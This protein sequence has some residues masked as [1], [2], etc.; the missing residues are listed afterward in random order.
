M[1]AAFCK[2]DILRAQAEAPEYFDWAVE[3]LSWAASELHHLT[4]VLA[5]GGRETKKGA[6]KELEA[7]EAHLSALADAASG[8][9]QILGGDIYDRLSTTGRRALIDAV[10]DL[11]SKHTTWRPG[12]GRL[13]V[14]DPIGWSVSD[15]GVALQRILRWAEVAQPIVK[16]GAE[17][18]GTAGADAGREELTFARKA[19]TIWLTLDRSDTEPVRVPMRKHFAEWLEEAFAF[20]RHAP[21]N[22]STAAEAVDELSF[23][24]RTT[25]VPQPP[26]PFPVARQ[27]GPNQ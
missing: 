2:K 12:A 9:Q 15:Q 27:Y 3:E 17:M 23:Q 26:P 7:L 6:R 13:E 5:P 8:I 11:G 1:V 14:P 22:K 19:R 18:L 24:A 25:G 10:Q 21:K 16:R 4:E 20:A